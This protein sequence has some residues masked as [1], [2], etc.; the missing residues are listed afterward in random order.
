ML[1]VAMAARTRN[2]QSRTF[3]SNAAYSGDDLA[4]LRL[5]RGAPAFAFRLRLTASA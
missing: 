1:A 3:A 4:A 2:F 5:P